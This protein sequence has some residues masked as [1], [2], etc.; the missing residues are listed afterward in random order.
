MT[1]YSQLWLFFVLVFGVVLLPGMDMAYVLGSALTGGRRA[2]LM[3]VA[4]VMTGAVCHVIAGVLGISV[5]LKLY[6]AAFKFMLLAGACYIAW[7]G[8]SILRS[9]AAFKMGGKLTARPLGITFRQGMLSC[10]MNPKAYLFMLAIFPQFLRPEYGTLW[11]QGVVMWLIIA[12][13]Q[14]G[15]YGGIAI[16]ADGVRRWLVQEPESALIVSRVVGAMLML[17]A[18]FTAVEGWRTA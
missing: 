4:G 9:A 3:A 18:V 13:N 11:I 2:G 5:L 15:V 7:I 17:A 10:L 6:P 8:W 12:V 16:A 14:A 1:H